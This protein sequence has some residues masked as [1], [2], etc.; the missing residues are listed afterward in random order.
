MDE[1]Q[2][3]SSTVTGRL[4]VSRPSTPELNSLAGLLASHPNVSQKLCKAGEIDAVETFAPGT[5]RGGL[6]IGPSQPSG[7]DMPPEVPKSSFSHY[8]L[9]SNSA[10][11]RLELVSERFSKGLFRGCWLHHRCR[12]V[13]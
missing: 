12:S 6:N 10:G 5:N 2:A 3:D 13:L 1:L 4:L 8:V 11:V 9:P 7:D